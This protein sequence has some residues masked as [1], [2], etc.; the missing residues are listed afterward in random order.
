MASG[1]HD[2]KLILHG[3]AGSPIRD[4]ERAS[5]VEGALCG[6]R[7]ELFEE[8]EAGASAQEVV[9]EGCRQLEDNRHFNA[10]TGSVLQSDGKIRLSAALMDGARGAF[11]GVVNATDLRHPIDLARFLQGEQD[12]VLASEGATAL[13]RE[14]GTPPHDPMT[15]KRLTEWLEQRRSDFDA[16]MAG[17]VAGG[18]AEQSEEDS[19]DSDASDAGGGMEPGHGTIGVVALDQNGEISAGTSTGGRGFER[20]GRV[21]DSATPAGNYAT[22]AA[23]VSCTGI[24]EDIIDECAAARIVVRVEDG[25]SIREAMQTSFDEAD[26]RGRSFGAIGIDADGTVAWAKTTDIL[27]A[28]WNTGTRR[29][30]TLNLTRGAVVEARKVRS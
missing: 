25:M 30:H 12:R 18:D 21:S 27:L 9:V 5:A 29:G 14:L 15:E 6:I 22:P 16:E 8:L 3:G 13:M 26:Q 10:G 20:V 4:R 28:A 2:P 19:A 11:S 17:V 7:D 23:G 1:R 24:G